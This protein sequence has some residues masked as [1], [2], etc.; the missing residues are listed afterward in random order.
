MYSA[1]SIVIN[2]TQI[3]TFKVYFSENDYF[4]YLLHVT[5]SKSEKNV[6]HI[7]VF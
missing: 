3:E 7:L 6:S 4:T 5:S 2:K 1:T